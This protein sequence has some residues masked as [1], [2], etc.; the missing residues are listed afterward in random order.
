[1][2]DLLKR[3][4]HCDPRTCGTDQ[5]ARCIVRA[6]CEIRNEAADEIERL[7]EKVETARSLGKIALGLVNLATGRDVMDGVD[8]EP[9]PDLTHRPGR[10]L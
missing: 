6:E 8:P 7:R 5:G 1:M 3:L 4:R 9:T 10:A 2:S